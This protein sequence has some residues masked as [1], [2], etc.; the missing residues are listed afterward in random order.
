M[1]A[2]DAQVILRA[3]K[4]EYTARE[5]ISIFFDALWLGPN[6]GQ[7]YVNSLAFPEIEV[8]Y[9][10]KFPIELT[11]TGQF[12]LRPQPSRH[13]RATY[14]PTMNWVS[15]AFSI[16]DPKSPTRFLDGK[17]GYYKFDRQGAFIIRATFR[18]E[19][20]FKLYEGQEADIQSTALLIRIVE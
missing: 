9:L 5:K 2:A 4:T 15:A 14:A 1:I 20:Q 19:S 18:Y 11:E 3:D 10:N 16:N 12:E 8:L 7:L 17:E 6:D 13:E